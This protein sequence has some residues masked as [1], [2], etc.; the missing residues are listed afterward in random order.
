MRKTN[1]KYLYKD[2][3]V[4]YENLNNGCSLDDIYI[5][6]KMQ[7]SK[8]SMMTL[9]KENKITHERFKV[10]VVGKDNLATSCNKKVLLC[11]TFFIVLKK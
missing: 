1:K 2:I 5:H 9:L 4:D 8:T 6:I 11:K 7:I 3:I 10:H